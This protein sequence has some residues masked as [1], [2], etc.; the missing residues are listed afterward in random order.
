MASRAVFALRSTDNCFF[1]CN[2]VTKFAL[3]CERRNFFAC[4]QHSVVQVAA[5]RSV[6]ILCFK[7]FL[8]EGKLRTRL[9]PFGLN[10]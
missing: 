2:A 6:I 9:V 10:Y 4:L 8:R 7:P 5:G 1:F 3:S